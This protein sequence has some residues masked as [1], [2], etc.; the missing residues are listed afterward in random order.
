MTKRFATEVNCTADSYGV[1]LYDDK[2]NL[3][4]LYVLAQFFSV[5]VNLKCTEGKMINSQE[6]WDNDLLKVMSP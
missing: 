1:S 5:S 6:L 2:S 3:H 4:I